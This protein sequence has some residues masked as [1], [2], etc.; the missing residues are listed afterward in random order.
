MLHH[1]RSTRV[2]NG[3]R[4]AAGSP[5]ALVAILGLALLGLPGCWEQV[6]VEWFPQMKWQEAVQ[7]FELNPYQEKIT[8]F[9]PPDGTVPV[10]WGDVARPQLL[11]PAEQEALQN[12]RPATLASLKNGER[13]FN[14]NCAACHGR[15]GGGDGPIAAP[16]GPIAGVLPIGPGSPMGFS[17]AP[18]LTDG[19]IYTTISLGRGRMPSYRRI[20]PEGRW[21]VVNYIRDLN[22]QGGR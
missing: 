8:L 20:P 22:G 2:A 10:G 11:S 14:V 3:R 12:P 18:A 13:Y 21:D 19:H 9:T 1:T 5:K 7:A 6:S 17:L 4:V 15:T 16:N